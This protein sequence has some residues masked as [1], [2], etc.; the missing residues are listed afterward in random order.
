MPQGR[1]RRNRRIRLTRTRFNLSLRGAPAH[2]E[3]VEERGDLD[4]AEHT[5]ANRRC[6]G[7]EIDTLRSQ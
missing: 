7:D 5:S 4:A 1:Q 6:Y 3:F 2:P